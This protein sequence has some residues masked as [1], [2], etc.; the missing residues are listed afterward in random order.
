VAG[1]GISKM[2]DFLFADKEW[3]AAVPRYSFSK[4]S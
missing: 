2:V 1:A 3:G 4:E